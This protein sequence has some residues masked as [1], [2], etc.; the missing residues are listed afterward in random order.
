MFGK[1]KQK[2]LGS[3]LKALFGIGKDQEAF[4][5]ELEDLLIEADVGPRL[6][7]TILEEL[8]ELRRADKFRSSEDLEEA[9]VRHLAAGIKTAVLAPEPGKLNCFLVFGVN[10]VGKTTSIAKMAKYYGGSGDSDGAAG[11]P[12][13]RGIVL[14]A[15][16]TFRAAAPEQL[17]IH[18][19]RL[20]IRLVSQGAGADPA[21]VVFD[22]LESARARGEELVIAD[23][24]GRM[25]TKDNLV[26]ELQKIVKTAQS[27]SDRV[28]R[29]LVLDST[30]GQ[31][32]LHQARTF[33][34]AVGIDAVILTK[35]DS[36][37]K[38]GLAFTVSREIGL[39]FAFTGSGESVDALQ[40]FD[41]AAFARGLVA[42]IG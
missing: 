16:D 29:V 7:G 25:H 9:L 24:A 8:D 19:Q 40:A 28:M 27:K 34:E 36:S 41:A 37:A 13:A 26:R 6:V 39:P 30:T 18:A 5:E 14:A 20:G 15:A 12:R 1:K 32:G 11:I 38:G 2:T 21:A 23:T 3:R 42:R 10:G 22:A 33:H 35:V 17:G 4:L 31:N